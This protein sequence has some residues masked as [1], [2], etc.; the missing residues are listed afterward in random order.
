MKLPLFL[1]RRSPM[2]DTLLCAHDAVLKDRL[3]DFLRSQHPAHTA[4]EVARKA[5]IPTRTVEHWLSGLSSPRLPHFLNLL[6]AYGPALL[7]A[8]MDDD[9][10]QR[11]SQQ[12]FDWVDRL[13]TIEDRDKATEDLERVTRALE[14][15]TAAR[16]GEAANNPFD[17]HQDGKKR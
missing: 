1:R 5:D 15:L 8:A 9:T 3:V 17:T 10:C 4:K 12:G 6:R 2:K 7:Q 13:K 16:P 14:A 11:M